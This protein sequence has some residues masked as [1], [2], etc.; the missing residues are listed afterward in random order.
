MT[1]DAFSSSDAMIGFPSPGHA[2][3]VHL[4]HISVCICTFKRPYYLADTLEKLKHQET[5]QRFTYSIVVVD[6]DAQKSAAGIIAQFTSDAEVNV[7]YYIE[8]QQNIALARNR[9]LENADGEYVAFIDD[10][11]FPEERWLVN[12]LATCQRYG[13]DGVLGPVAPSFEVNPPDWILRGS[14]FERPNHDTGQVLHWKQTRTGNVLLR[15]PIF[16]QTGIWFRPEFGTGGEDVDFFRRMTG[17]GHSFVWCREAIVYE[18]VPASRATRSYLLR[19]ALLR[20]SNFS[21]HRTG[22]W[23]SVGMSVIAIP[24]YTL[25]LPVLLILGQHMFM[26]YLVR[27]CDHVSRVFAL[28]GIRLAREREM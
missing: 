17:L 10:D 1:V 18:H 12:L 8:P 15:R 14:F 16:Q 22:R 5:D 27:L 11:E 7:R 13:V 4:P 20:G 25:L 9:A 24:A 21:K 26:D 19:R 23:R 2:E 28:F 3:P 6:N